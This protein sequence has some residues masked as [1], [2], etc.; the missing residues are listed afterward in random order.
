MHLKGL[1]QCYVVVVCLVLDTV[2]CSTVREAL[3]RLGCSVSKV[4]W[5][6]IVRYV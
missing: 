5:K 4:V 6:Q 3:V 1:Q 2:A